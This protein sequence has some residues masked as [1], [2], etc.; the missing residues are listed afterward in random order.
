MDLAELNTGERIGRIYS[1]NVSLF[2]FFMCYVIVFIFNA[3][4]VS[5]I[6][7][8]S[9]FQKIVFIFLRNQFWQYKTASKT[10]KIIGKV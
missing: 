3:L 7:Y 10:R 9:K 4:I 6:V 8:D 5:F 2:L 1:K